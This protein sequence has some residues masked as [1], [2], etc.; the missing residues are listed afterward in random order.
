MMVKRSILFAFMSL[1]LTMS[2]SG[3]TPETHTV[4]VNSIEDLQNY[5]RYSPDRDVIVS[6]HRGGMMAGYPENCIESCEKT[7][8]MM[9]T[10]FEIDFSFTADSVMVLM[11]DLSIDRTTNGKGKISDY[12]YEQLQGF[13]LIDRNGKLTPY[14]IPTLKQMLEWGKDKVVFN[15]DNKYI[16]TKGV[17]DSVKQAALEYYYRQLSP[18]GDWSMYHN[19]MLSVRSLDEA[20]FYWNRGLRNVMFCVEISTPEQFEAYDASPIPWNYIMAYIR[21]SVNP[22]MQDIYN[23][24]HERGVMTMTSITATSDK[25]K[26]KIDR[27]TAYHRELLAEPDIIETDYPSEF[28]GLPQSRKEIHAQQDAAVV[29]RKVS[30]KK[31]K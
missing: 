26:N 28:I 3:K 15:F 25:V 11:H 19:I 21:T 16:N 23:K 5:F 14:K 8:S 18:G 10:F 2:V 6:S 12:T 9:P 30:V 31:A 22:D 27:R 13:N 24:L 20:L 1:A 7:L 17:P 29:A 4:K